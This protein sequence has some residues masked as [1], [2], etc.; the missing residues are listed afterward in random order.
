MK[1][2]QLIVIL[3]IS[4]P[5]QSIASPCD[6]TKQNFSE[7]IE[8]FKQEQFLL[9]SQYFVITKNFGNKECKLFFLASYFQAASFLNL[10][11]LKAFEI[12]MVDLNQEARSK[13]EIN[14]TKLLR[15]YAYNNGE[16]NGVDIDLKKRWE[17]WQKR[18]AVSLAELGNPEISS[19]HSNYLE[20]SNSKS[21]VL[22]GVLSAI[23]PGGGQ[24]YVGAYQSAALAFFF[25]ALLLG[26]TLDFHRKDMGMAAAASG[27][28]FS[29][30][31]LG[32]IVSA[33]KGANLVNNKESRPYE[34]A[35]RGLMLPEL[36][37]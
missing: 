10:K 5:L 2:F 16:I 13:L 21:P 17:L 35:L 14:Q 8:F 33:V 19:I 18:K 23:I 26:A 28:L 37:F 7:G 4:F 34:N 3:I 11:D 30:T 27:T 6:Q 12:A 24:A 32:N 1:I 9:A 31:Y 36:Q 25:N 22:A 15:A 29:M 20:S